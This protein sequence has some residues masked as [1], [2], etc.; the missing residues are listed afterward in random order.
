MEMK[1]LRKTLTCIAIIVELCACTRAESETSAVRETT[2]KETEPVTTT[3]PASSKAPEE[4]ETESEE[5]TTVPSSDDD[6]LS[7]YKPIT[8]EEF[9]SFEVTLEGKDVDISKPKDYSA[10][11]QDQFDKT[12]WYSLEATWYSP[13]ANAAIRLYPEGAFVYYP[14]ISEIGDVLYDWELIDRSNRGK[15]PELAIY[16]LGRDAGPL[17]F[18]VSRITDDY[19]YCI[20]QDYTFYRQ[21]DKRFDLPSTTAVSETDVTK[22]KK[23]NTAKTSTGVNSSQKNSEPT[24]EDDDDDET[25]SYGDST[26][27]M[28]HA[29]GY[30]DADDY[31]GD[32]ADEYLDTGDY[33]DYDDAY[34][35]AHEDFENYEDY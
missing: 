5:E 14:D 9:N 6:T 13:E 4:I 28:T 34:E 29:S 10:V 21:W 26:L 24:T 32:Y 30:D 35:A 22:E 11:T 25:L 31:A 16:T 8:E 27:Y 2:A 17:A 18:Y 1:N 23:T 33:E 7:G 3:A 19:F 20:Q 12:T 15:C